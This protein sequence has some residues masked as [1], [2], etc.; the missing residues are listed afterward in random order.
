MPA[1]TTLAVTQVVSQGVGRLPWKGARCA[2]RL[3]S[4][5]WG[6]AMTDRRFR[7]G[8]IRAAA[9]VLCG[10]MV[11]ASCAAILATKISDIKKTPGAFEG[12]TVT[13]AGKVTSTYNLVLVKYYEVDDGSGTIP[14]VT[15]SALPK[16]GESV[17]VKGRV[18]QAFA[19]GTARLVVVVE[20]PPPR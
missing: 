8:N 18:N 4:R 5:E 15:E 16:E 10:L 6:V 12:R 2:R 17:R 14:V 7:G 19:L 13:I 20:E 11:L 3:E 1:G 9:Q